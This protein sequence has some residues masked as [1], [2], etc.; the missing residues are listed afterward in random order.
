MSEYEVYAPSEEWMLRHADEMVKAAITVTP[1]R[2]FAKPFSIITR[3]K[4]VVLLDTTC[5]PVCV[6]Q[7]DDE[8]PDK[9]SEVQARQ[10]AKAISELPYLETDGAQH[11]R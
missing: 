10:I 5:F 9:V 4:T 6:V 11:S 1:G 3:G 2:H 7:F 8:D